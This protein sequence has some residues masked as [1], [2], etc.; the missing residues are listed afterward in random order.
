MLLPVVHNNLLEE[1][2]VASRRCL[3]THADCCRCVVLSGS[4]DILERW[5]DCACGW[6]HQHRQRV[7]Y[8]TQESR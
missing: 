5:D 6:H 1:E 2:S 7:Q 4:G 3:G 8:T